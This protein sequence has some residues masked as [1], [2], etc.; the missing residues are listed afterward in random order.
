[1]RRLS[2]IVLTAIALL[3]VACGEKKQHAGH[4]LVSPAEFAKEM[5]EPGTV[6]L[7]VLGI[8]APRI[9]GTDLEIAL[10]RLTSGHSMPPN[11][12]ALAVYCWSG[13]T[14]AAAI[15]VLEKLGYT[16]IVELDGGMQAWQ[17]DGRKLIQTASSG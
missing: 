1:M 11:S 7:N 17:A 16:N 4:R 14:S 12:A 15:P 9:P 10:E 8:D 3:S 13:R 5:S 6:T 2:V